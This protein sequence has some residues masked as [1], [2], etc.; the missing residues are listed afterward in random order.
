MAVINVEDWCS[1][2]GSEDQN[3]DGSVTWDPLERG[4]WIHKKCL[5][6]RR[7]QKKMELRMTS[8]Q[9]CTGS[10]NEK[11]DTVP[12]PDGEGRVHVQ[13]L[14]EHDERKGI[15]RTPDQFSPFPCSVCGKLLTEAERKRPGA[16]PGQTD[17]WLVHEACANEL[18]SK[19]TRGQVDTSSNS[20]TVVEEPTP[21]PTARARARAIEQELEQ[22]KQQEAQARARVAQLEQELHTARQAANIESHEENAR[23]WAAALWL[24][25][26][27]GKASL[28]SAGT[29]PPRGWNHSNSE[30]EY[31]FV[32]F[33]GETVW[34]KVSHKAGAR[35]PAAALD[36]QAG[37]AETPHH[38]IDAKGR[39]VGRD[40]DDT[41]LGGHY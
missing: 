3:P 13:C 38:E 39:M 19:R 8:C 4:R 14:V 22:T 11:G 15:H 10:L 37:A 20:P 31:E 25:L 40:R 12:N 41:P 5:D 27:H 36:L 1:W 24:C 9:L 26:Q 23:G 18:F 35:P 28:R 34:M 29:L 33:S 30:S 16:G 7:E 32:L 2:C 21:P 17:G 6:K